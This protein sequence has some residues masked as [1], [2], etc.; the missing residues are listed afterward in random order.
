MKCELCDKQAV[1]ILD[2][3]IIRVGY[4][5]AHYFKKLLKTKKKKVKREVNYFE[6][7]V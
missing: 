1:K 3:G 2:F 4:C 5:K 7:M 6:K